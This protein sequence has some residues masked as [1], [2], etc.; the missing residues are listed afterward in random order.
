MADNDKHN[1][2]STLVLP[3][4]K[5]IT[6]SSTASG[7]DKAGAETT[8]KHPSHAGLWIVIILTLLIAAGTAAAGYWFLWQKDSGQSALADEQSAQK[9]ILGNLND[10][11]VQ[12][13]R[14]LIELEKK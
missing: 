1:T 13:Q 4:E 6:P 8:S 5:D 14:K 3:E 2:D 11:N 10:E 7:K 9:A 12:L